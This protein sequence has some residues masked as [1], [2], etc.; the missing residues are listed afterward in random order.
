MKC[1]VAR[2]VRKLRF[3]LAPA[4]VVAGCATGD[5]GSETAAPASAPAASVDQAWVATQGAK[6]IVLTLEGGEEATA[7][8]MSTFPG[9]DVES[10]YQ[11]KAKGELVD[12]GLYHAVS[13][14]LFC[15]GGAECD[16]GAVWVIECTWA[17]GSLQ[18]QG[19]D[20]VELEEV[21]TG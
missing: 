12:D 20:F 3:G 2:I 13:F 6:F 9:G 17:D 16:F 14:N 18:C 1:S 19:F 11:G 5:T 8:I 4:L 10:R 15:E 21:A 7:D